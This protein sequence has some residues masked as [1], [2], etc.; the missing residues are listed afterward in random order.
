MM[1]MMM[2]MIWRE[3]SRLRVSENSVLR[4]IFV[5]TKNEVTGE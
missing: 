2:M 3:K 4:K 1:M 5:S